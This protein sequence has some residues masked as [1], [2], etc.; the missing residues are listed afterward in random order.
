MREIHADGRAL[1]QDGIAVTVVREEFAADAQRVLGR[2]THA[3]HP[4]VAAH[5]ADG[6]PHLV[7]EGL[8]SEL[9]IGGGEGRGNCIAGTLF[10]LGGKEGIDSLGETP[11]EEM[12]V[13]LEGDVAVVFH[14]LTR[15]MEAVDGV[16]EK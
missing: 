13:S 12:T 3:K 6:F 1:Q 11:R 4:L 5:G 8:E 7:G 2:V 16:E 9:V 15:E 14:R 10:A